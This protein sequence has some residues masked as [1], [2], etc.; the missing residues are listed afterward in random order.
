MADALPIVNDAATWAARAQGARSGDEGFFSFYSSVV[1][2]VTT[3]V[4]LMAV[5]IDDHAIVR[6]HA[7]FDTC[8]LAGG[9]MYRLQVHLDR[10]LASAASAR[11][12]LP[13]GADEATN[14][15][16]MIEVVRA[17]CAASGRQNANVRFWLTAGTG[18][19]GVTPGGCTAQFYVLTFGGMPM[20]ASWSEDGIPEVTVPDTVVPLKPPHLAELKS[21]NYMLNALLCMAAKDRGGTFGIGVESS[22]GLLLE[23][24][25]LNVVV[26]GEDRSLRTPPFRRVLKGT[27]VRRAMELAKRHLLA[28][29]GELLSRVA[30]EPITAEE[31]RGATEVF[32]LAGDTHVYPIISLDGVTIGEGKPGPVCMA[33]KRLLEEDAMHGDEAHEP[34]S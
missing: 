27:T 10:L 3:N 28:P 7:V 29:H 19:L 22:S 34:V 21:N 33:L 11:L 16:K 15:Q 4:A 18:N 25:V 8:S 1:G 2:A 24:C 23:S 12:P 13:F 32:L 17:T 14:R 6:G 9:R 30:Q 20:P 5:P 31:A 26:V